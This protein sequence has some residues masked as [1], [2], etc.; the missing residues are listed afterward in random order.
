MFDGGPGALGEGENDGEGEGKGLGGAAVPA[1]FLEELPSD[2]VAATTMMMICRHHIG[3]HNEHAA[4]PEARPCTGL[5][6]PGGPMRSAC[7]WEDRHMGE[8]PWGQQAGA[9]M[10]GMCMGPTRMTPP[11]SAPPLRI[12]RSLGDLL[13]QNSSNRAL[14]PPLR[15]PSLSGPQRW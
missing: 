12:W 5:T 8:W 7:T 15:L 3:G 11:S 4:A 6:C 10:N 9:M 14:M 13:C 1:A 2:E